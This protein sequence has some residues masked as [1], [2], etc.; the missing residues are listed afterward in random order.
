MSDLQSLGTKLR[1]AREAH[2]LSLAELEKRTRIRPRFLQAMENGQFQ[3][4]DNP[5]QLRGFLRSYA[6]AVGLDESGIV[7]EYEVA[8][9]SDA[10]QKRRRKQAAPPPPPL[11]A[12]N[13]PVVVTRQ[14]I[15]TQERQP[16]PALY[17]AEKRPWP[18]LLLA[19]SLLIGVLLAVGGGAFLIVRDLTD[20][21]DDNS[22]ILQPFNVGISE[23]M[24]PTP[25]PTL[26]VQPT[27]VAPPVVNLGEPINVRITARQRLWV[28]VTVDDR[29]VFTGMLRPG[30]GAAYD[31]TR[32]VT[33]KTTN[34]GGLEVLVNNQIYE[35]GAD[36]QAVQRRIPDDL[37]NDTSSLP[38]LNT[39]R[40]TNPTQVVAVPSPLSA[41]TLATPASQNGSVN[42][43]KFS[44]P[45]VQSTVDS[46]IPSLTPTSELSSNGGIVAT[47]TL[48]PTIGFAT[49]TATATPS[50]VPPTAT[51]TFTPSPFLPPRHTRTPTLDKS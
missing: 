24:Q 19:V 9:A 39:S 12:P 8:L 33:I 13:Q 15:S 23:D 49:N 48:I 42:T 29:V 11:P 16:D 31:A 17:R 4:I 36:R 40:S 44:S 5:L 35:L 20:D 50:P 6:K 46:L 37:G 21:D 18:Q 1:E 43:G 30:D 38:P 2:E 22:Q 34:A 27:Q 41:D 10:K 32:Y 45:V 26:S 28:Q 14:P 25:S 7:N 47:S 3:V 51:P